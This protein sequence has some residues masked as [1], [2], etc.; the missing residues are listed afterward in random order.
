MDAP[1][2]RRP[3]RTA[4]L[5]VALLACAT[6]AAA[7]GAATI[8]WG[9]DLSAAPDHALGAAV[10]TVYW[11]TRSARVKARAPRRGRVAAV[12]V[13][14]SAVAGACLRLHCSTR[15]ERTILFQDLR[16]LRGGK[17]RVVATSQPFELPATDAIYSFEPTGFF[18]KRG[19]Y[20]GIA[21]LGGAFEVFA[22]VS[23]S[24]IARFTGAGRDRNG[25]R[26]RGGPVSRTELLLKVT[27]RV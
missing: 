17:L 22:T 1:A 15:Y 8:T 7:A 27:E 2:R 4:A 18:V 23:G 10:D 26:L 14:G 9:S 6:H 19:D 24:S 25:A 20:V 11:S 21:T 16:R 3:A 12:A 13:R 5:A